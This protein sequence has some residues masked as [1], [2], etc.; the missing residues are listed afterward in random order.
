M[1]SFWTATGFRA[2]PFGSYTAEKE[3]ELDRYLVRPAYF[4][5][6]SE[7][8]SRI[9]SFLLFGARGAGK[10][11]SRIALYKATMSRLSEGK[12]CPLPVTFDSFTAVLRNG[13]DRV[14][15]AALVSELAYLACEATLVWLAA[16]E[17]GDRNTYVEGMDADEKKLAVWLLDRFYFTRPEPVRQVATRRALELLDQAWPKRTLLWAQKKWNAL[18]AIVGGLA[19][20]SRRRPRVIRSA[21]TRA[22][23]SASCPMAI[24]NESNSHGNSYADGRFRPDL[25]QVHGRSRADRQGR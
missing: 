9:E 11:A 5:S 23:T 13:I 12:A 22:S 16:L 21:W 20:S 14:S 8:S 15:V 7:R 10:S 4:E 2:N 6:L 1:G 19:D 3:P 24:A 17:E 18:A 25:L